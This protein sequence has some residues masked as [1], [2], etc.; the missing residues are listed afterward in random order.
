MVIMCWLRSFGQLK[1]EHVGRLH[2][3][4]DVRISIQKTWLGAKPSVSLENL[5]I[6][7]ADI[8]G[9]SKLVVVATFHIIRVTA[10]RLSR[11]GQK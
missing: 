3:P 1:P 5:P 10:F 4:L 8:C 9:S 2:H 7:R 11:L 6:P